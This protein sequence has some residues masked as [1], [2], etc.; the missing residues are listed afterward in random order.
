[1][2]KKVSSINLD[3]T[4]IKSMPKFLIEQLDNK[5]VIWKKHASGMDKALYV[6]LI[7]PHGVMFCKPHVKRSE[8]QNHNNLFC[9]FKKFLPEL[10]DIIPENNGKFIEKP[11]K[12]NL[13]YNNQALKDF[14]DK[15]NKNNNDQL[16]EYE[17]AYKIKVIDFIAQIKPLMQ[18]FGVQTTISRA[19]DKVT[20]KRSLYEKIETIQDNLGKICL[21]VGELTFVIEKNTHN[22]KLI[23][24]ATG[25]NGA[26]AKVN[27][28]QISL[29]LN[30]I[31][32]YIKSN[33][34]NNRSNVD[35]EYSRRPKNN[36]TTYG[37][38]YKKP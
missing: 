15:L 27:Q 12:T 3:E 33:Y 34:L 2:N 20:D 30:N 8:R 4:A 13:I 16:R 7:D 10:I 19:I 35:T 26:S 14:Y 18:R 17:P 6:N 25:S 31:Q 24:L 22:I 5:S 37:S 11:S 28:R 32:K 21:H 23:D 29:G 36:T 38:N 9:A 1:M